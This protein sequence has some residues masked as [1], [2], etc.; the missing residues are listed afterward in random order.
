[1][2]ARL[3]LSAPARRH[4]GHWRAT[5][6]LCMGLAGAAGL[7]Q[8]P[9][10]AQAS[11]AAT[12]QAENAPFVV[13]LLG[14]GSPIPDTDRFGPAILLEAGEQF[15]LFDAG[16]G[17]I[18]RIYS[19]GIPF[20]KIDKLFIT[21]LHSDHTA[22]LAD[23]F[24][25]SW[26]RGRRTPFHIWG[27]KGVQTLMSQT[28]AAYADDID[29]R[30]DQSEGA[31]AYA[32]DMTE[33]VVYERDGVVVTAFEVDHVA[34]LKSFGFRIA[35]QGKSVVLSGDTRYNENLI[36]HAQGVD[37]LV[38]EV[39]AVSETMASKTPSTQKIVNIHT[40]PED[41][42]RVFT[43]VSPGLA[44]YSHIVL[45]DVSVPELLR[46]TRKT[47][48]GPLVVGEDLMSF[49]LSG[50]KGAYALSQTRP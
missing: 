49:S 37:L 19:L 11:A 42:G 34:K 38:H 23:V 29:S 9:V 35:Y 28:L 1:M 44:V 17:A 50:K 8:Q 27:P 15:L 22:G 33:G 3:S 43:A 25:T 46:R 6:A 26:L 31:K 47:Y 40:T 39:A 48:D 14:T 45:F 32:K 2:A 12:E 16:R 30:L 5:L 21:H 41:A 36:K 7:A 18:Q 13:H 20:A 10:Q 4:A 24:L